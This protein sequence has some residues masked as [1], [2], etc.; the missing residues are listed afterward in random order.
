MNRRARRTE[1]SIGRI[2]LRPISASA[3]RVLKTVTIASGVSIE[4][5]GIALSIINAVGAESGICESLFFVAAT[6]DK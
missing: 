1:F 5:E 3:E 2:I 4:I 6:D